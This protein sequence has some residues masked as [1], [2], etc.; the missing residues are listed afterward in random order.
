VLGMNTIR[1]FL[2]DLAW[3]ADREG[4]KKRIN[5]FLEVTDRLG[6]RPAFV[7]FD[8]CWNDSPRIGK[9]PEPI[10]GVHNS[11]WLQ[12]PGKRVVNDPNS[13]SRLELYIKGIIGEFV[14]D[15]RILFWDLYNEPSNSGQESKSLPLLKKVFKW[16]RQIEP[17][18]PL[19]CGIWS[20][21]KTIVDFQ[22]QQ[23][24]IISFHNY[25]DTE[26]LADKIAQ[27]HKYGRPLFCTEWLRRGYSNVATHLPIFK[28]ERVGC[29]NWGLV[30]GKTQTI[31]PWGSKKGSPEPKLWFHDLLWKNGTP[32][33]P[34]E[35]KLFKKLTAE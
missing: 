4:L 13:W 11:G 25:S 31:Y 12:S 28:R 16:A 6:I 20:I 3:E 5:E 30:S 10:L 7:I 9:Q 23:S 22:L 24:D 18:Q 1:V 21:E 26:N 8:D 14:N 32:F 35:T 34:K 27:L 15:R 2:H 29:Y 17:I 33:D 19:T